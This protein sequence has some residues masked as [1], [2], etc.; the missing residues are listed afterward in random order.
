MNLPTIIIMGPTGVGK[1]D[2]AETLARTIDGE[3]INCDLGQFYTPLSIGTAKPDWRRSDIPHHMFD[4]LDTPENYSVTAYRS[5]VEIVIKEITARGKIPIIVGGSGF[6]VNALFFPPQDSPITATP[7]EGISHNSLQNISWEDL[8]AIDP[9]RAQKIHPHDAYRIERALQLWHTTGI[10][11]SQQKPFYRPVSDNCF[12]VHI[13]RDR[14][15]LY[16]RINAR[17]LDMILGSSDAEEFSFDFDPS[18]G[19]VGEVRRLPEVWH[20]FL[21]KKGVIGYSE[22]LYLLQELQIPIAHQIPRLITAIQ[23]STRHYAKRQTTYWRMLSRKLQ[24]QGLGERIVEA[25]LT[26]SPIDLYIRQLSSLCAMDRRADSL[27]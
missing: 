24:E 8:F 27:D 17:T 5:Q 10:L 18:L 6:Y 19:W 11:P 25:N 3:I 4:I 14:Q 26:L 9:E 22:I 1:S 2:F 20:D 15:E 13:E 23:K 7:Q 16:E 12:I 21:T